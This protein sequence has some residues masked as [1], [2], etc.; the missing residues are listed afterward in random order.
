M[1]SWVFS[2]KWLDSNVRTARAAGAD[3]K[4]KREELS[5]LARAM[6][7]RL[8]SK[9]MDGNKEPLFWESRQ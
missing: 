4:K 8:N 9:Q 1:T 5:G 3:G 2:E 6:I 7:R